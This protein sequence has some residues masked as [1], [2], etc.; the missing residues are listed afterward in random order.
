MDARAG[1]AAGRTLTELPDDLGR[2]ECW[3]GEDGPLIVG[4][5]AR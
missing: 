2:F 1:A 4:D 3:V 5:P